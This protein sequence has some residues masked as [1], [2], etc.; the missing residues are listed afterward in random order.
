[1]ASSSVLAPPLDFGTSYKLETLKKS[2]DKVLEVHQY[3]FVH[4][5]KS[6]QRLQAL[7]RSRE[8]PGI[9]TWYACLVLCLVAPSCLALCDPVWTIAHQAPPSMEFPRQE[10]WSE[11]P[12]LPLGD[13]P[14]PGIEPRSPALQEDSLPLSHLG[15]PFLSS[16]IFKYWLILTFFSADCSFL[17]MLC[18]KCNHCGFHCSSVGLADF[19]NSGTLYFPYNLS[20]LLASPKYEDAHYLGF[21]LIVSI[22]VTFSCSFNIPRELLLD[23]NLSSDKF[24]LT[25]PGCFVHWL[26]EAAFICT[27]EFP[28]IINLIECVQKIFHEGLRRR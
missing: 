8:H 3:W 1:M 16:W 15:S 7:L 4:Q 13:L 2:C 6:H 23:T 20:S 9:L 11:L 14:D 25:S 21:F 27:F 12:F 22:G 28:Q 18:Q 10:Y 26:F 24:H 5:N 19:W 17:V